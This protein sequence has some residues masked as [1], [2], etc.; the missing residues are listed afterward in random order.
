LAF[1]FYL[2]CGCGVI[3]LSFTFFTS[4]IY[5]RLQLHRDPAG[6]R[7]SRVF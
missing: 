4:V 6:L 5:V 1:P 3:I 7:V 2:Y